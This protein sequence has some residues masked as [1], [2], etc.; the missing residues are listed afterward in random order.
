MSLKYRNIKRSCYYGF[1]LI[2]FGDKR[3]IRM[4]EPEKALIDLLYL[5]S[6]IESDEDFEAWRFNK[7][8]ILESIKHS[9]M[10]QYAVLMNN[11]S[12]YQ[13]YKRFQKWLY[14]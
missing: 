14:A 9:R 13:R 5:E 3:H 12:F 10:E 6:S 4:A 7:S 8:M 11:Q 1:T 2:P